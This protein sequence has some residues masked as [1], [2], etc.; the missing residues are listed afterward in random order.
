MSPVTV[1]VVTLVP[2]EL[3]NPSFAG[4]VHDTEMDVESGMY[5]ATG[6]R[7]GDGAVG[8]GETVVVVVVGGGSVVVVVV[9]TG[10]VVVVVVGGDTFGTSTALDAVEGPLV[11][12][13]LVAVTV[14]V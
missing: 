10:G 3:P 4:A 12:T 5:D 7:G 6:A 1:Y 9:T 2:V 8:D 11:P 13:E 14:K